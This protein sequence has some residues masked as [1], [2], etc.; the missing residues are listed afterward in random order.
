MEERKS[1]N[2]TSSIQT[3]RKASYPA[4]SRMREADDLILCSRL[5]VEEPKKRGR[6]AL[7]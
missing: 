4:P 5:K 6:G 7:L 2:K 1:H 3:T